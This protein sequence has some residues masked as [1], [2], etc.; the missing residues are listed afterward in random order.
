MSFINTKLKDF[1]E[2]LK[3]KK[4]AI[5]G[6][7]VSN[8]P[9]IDYL[10]DFQAKITVFDKRNEEKIDK[11]VLEKIEN[12]KISKNFGENYLSN[13][14]DFDIIFKSPSCRPDLPEIEAEVKR[15]AIL[16]SEIEKVLE[17][18]PCKI[19][20]VTGSDGKTTTT[21]LIYEIVKQKYKAYLGGNI[22]IPLFTKI[23]EMQPE[24]IVV[25]ELSSFQLMTM[26]KSPDIAVVTN[27]TP[28]HLD[29]HKS[30]EEYIEAK[31]NI[32]LNQNEDNTLVLNYDNEIT[33]NFA[34]TAKSKV[35]FFSS[36]EK[37][38][39]GV[40]YDDGII[41]VSED[42][43]RRH[44]LKLKDTH[45]RGTHNAE[46]ICA[47]V[48]ATK[49][50]VQIEDQINAIKGFEGVPHRIEFV[51]EINGSKWYN[52]SIASSPTRTIAGL[53]SF[54]EEIV[55]IAGG[56]DKH[57]DY[58][59]IAKPILDKVK[60]LILLGQTSGKILNAVK[61]KQGELGIRIDIF[62]VDTLEEAVEKAKMEAKPNQVVLFS[63]ASAS[64]DMFKN[65][66]ERG[67][68]FKELVKNL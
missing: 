18:A 60:T 25:L 52:D 56:Y 65:F 42:G 3:N 66:E 12:Y 2:N 46:N 57:L 55:L 24:D 40:I 58:E 53:N 17:L 7:G 54:D 21:S 16:T 61:E 9:L 50:L 29:I 64:F 39:N 45:L 36:K 33:K 35:I 13:L 10:H 4:I 30:Y 26:K 20:A 23:K 68:K 63:P 67:N 34:K 41:K 1:E 27:V 32:F 47:A 19:I 44:L 15:G 31:K 37:I 59:P 28:N 14:K 11:G 5:I 48:A 49:G 43:L 62:K 38:E 8:I 51:R 22:G 6:L